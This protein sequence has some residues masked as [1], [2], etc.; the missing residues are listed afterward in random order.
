MCVCVVS[1][2]YAAAFLYSLGSASYFIFLAKHKFENGKKKILHTEEKY[3][4]TGKHTP[5]TIEA[6]EHKTSEL[7]VHVY[8]N[9]TQARVS[10]CRRVDDTFTR[11]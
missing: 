4:H 8:M 2:F 3:R 1:L 6:I 10:L 11:R 7:A 5:H 9:V